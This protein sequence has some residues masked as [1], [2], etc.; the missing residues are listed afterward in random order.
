MTVQVSHVHSER[1]DLDDR[2]EKGL[3]LNNVISREEASKIAEKH[4][5]GTSQE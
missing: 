2:H 5:K 3:D 4:A 1:L